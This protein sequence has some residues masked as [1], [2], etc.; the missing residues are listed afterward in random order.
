MLFLSND[1]ASPPATSNIELPRSA[2]DLILAQRTAAAP[3][4]LPVIFK[5]TRGWQA[6]RPQLTDDALAEELDW[7]SWP[8]P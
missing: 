7:L 2:A 6:S 5:E 4:W 1:S 3:A 8:P